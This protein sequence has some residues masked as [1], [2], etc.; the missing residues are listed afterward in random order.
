MC[1]MLAI[2]SNKPISFSYLVEFK[3][4]AEK[5][6]ISQKAHKPGHKDGWGVLLYQK[7][8]PVYLGR[9][10]TNAM[11]DSKYEK[12]CKTLDKLGA[13]K[14]P[15]LA[16]LRKASSEYGQRTVENTAPFLREKWSF[17]HNGTIHNFNEKVADLRGTTDSE[18]F[19]LLILGIREE[20]QLPIEKALKLAIKKVRESYRYSSLTFILTNGTRIYAYREYSDPRD[21]D[22]YNLMFAID[23]N[24]VII[25]QEKLWHREWVIIPNRVLVTVLKNQRVCFEMI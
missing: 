17:M 6:L 24:M 21:S 5:G 4:L 22:Y 18:R 9:H 11:E 23:S 7:G 14:G 1:R 12:A 16:H 13:T 3:L 10:P 15:L 8:E 19:F 25:S 20:S 2:M